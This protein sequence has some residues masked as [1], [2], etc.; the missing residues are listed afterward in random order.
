M[1]A[2]G[3]ITSAI[4][5]HPQASRAPRSVLTH[6]NL[7]M[8]SDMM[9]VMLLNDSFTPFFF[10]FFSVGAAWSSKTVKCENLA[11]VVDSSGGARG[12][13]S[14]WFPDLVS[15]RRRTQT[16]TTT[17]LNTKW[18]WLFNHIRRARTLEMLLKIPGVITSSI[19]IVLF[20]SSISHHDKCRLVINQVVPSD[21]FQM[22]LGRNPF[23]YLQNCLPSFC[24]KALSY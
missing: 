11:A 6:A 2:K 16:C 10:S 17:E 7:N 5:T 13:S 20:K 9:M 18:D 22:K 15:V 4:R 3:I 14:S 8:N 24:W 21:S 12:Q 1:C 19:F 23:P